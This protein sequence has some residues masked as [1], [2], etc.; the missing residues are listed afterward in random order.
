[1]TSMTKGGHSATLNEIKVFVGVLNAVGDCKVSMTF[2]ISGLVSVKG[3]W[4]QENYLFYRLALGYRVTQAHLSLAFVNC[5]PAVYT[6][7]YR[8][9]DR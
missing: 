7:I 3:S 5:T 6:R 4:A 2:G 9:L 8:P 1:M